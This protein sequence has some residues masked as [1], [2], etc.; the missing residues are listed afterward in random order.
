VEQ[1]SCDIGIAPLAEI[2]TAQIY[3]VTA[4]R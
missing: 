3:F 4:Q 1:E 2:Q